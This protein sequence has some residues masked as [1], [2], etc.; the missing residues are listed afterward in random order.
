M[1]HVAYLVIGIA[2]I[3]AG[4]PAFAQACLPRD[5]LVERLGSSY[6]EQVRARGLADNAGVVE[7]FIAPSGSWT[8][9]LTMPNGISCLIAAGEGGE[10][11]EAVEG[12]PA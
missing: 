10:V 12:D 11:I 5:A 7:F 9:S 4:L 8:L 6:G 3:L 1:R 2:A